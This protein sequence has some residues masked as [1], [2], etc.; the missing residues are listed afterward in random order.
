MKRFLPLLLMLLLSP[1][2]YS[3]VGTGDIAFLG[4]NIDA[5]T[6][7][8]SNDD[9]TFIVLE[10]IAGGE[11]FY[12]TEEGW[13]DVTNDWAGTSEG[14]IT[15]TAPV[16]GLACG[17][18]VH[19]NESSSNT[20]TVTGGGTATLGSGTGWSLTGGDQVIAYEAAV[21]EPSTVPTF[22]SGVHLDDGNGTPTSL[23]AV[24]GWNDASALVALGTAQSSLPPGLTNG[25]NC[26]SINPAI[27][28]EEDNAKYTGSLTGTASAVRALINDRLNWDDNDLTAYN[29]STSQF[30]A[31]VTCPAPCSDPTVPT[32]T[33][34]PATVCSGNN[35]TLN[36]SGTLNDATAWHVYTGSCGGT[37]VGSTM[38]SSISVTPSSPSTTY[39]VRG[40]GGCVTP[41]SCGSVTV[42][43]T[44]L[45]DAG[46]NYSASSYCVNDT[47][48]TPTITGLGG[49]TF[50][51]SPAGL[52]LTSGTGAIDVSL[53]TP[54]TYTVTYT[55]AGACPNSS[56][57]NVT[58]NG[59]DN[60]SFSYSASSYCVSDSDPTP[61]ITGLGGGTF[62]SSP[63][64][65]S[66]TS[67]T[68]AIDVS[69]STPGT[70]TVTYTT[71]GACP[72]SSNVNVT[73]NG[74]DNASF[75]Y[76]A[77]SYCVSDSDPT[78]TITGLGGGTFSS[79]P[80]G[81]SLTSGTGAIDV[82]LSTPGTYTVTYTTAGACPNSSN[83]NVTINGLDDASF[84]YSAA[85]YCQAASDPTPTISGLGGGTFSSSPAGLSLT[86]GTGA[87]DL[88][89]STPGTY[90]V[91]YT[92]AGACPNSSNVNV[93]VSTGS[94]T[95]VC[96]NITIYLD[97][98]GN[99]TITPADIDGGSSVSCGSL[100]LSASVTSFTCANIGP[101]IV[102][103]TVSNGLGNNAN[104][105][106][107]VTVSDTISPVITCP[108]NQTETPN[109]SCQFT[110][111]NYTG[112]A[113]ATDNC[114]GSPTIT[115]SPTAG[116]VISGNTTVTLTA[117]DGNGNTSSCTFDVTLNDATAPAA[118]C[119]NISVFLDGSGNATITAGDI[120]GGSSDNCSGISLSASPT[121]FTCADLGANNVTLT[122][123]DGNANQAAC[124]A[125]VTVL[126]TISPTA[127]C[128]NHTVTL[129]GSGNASMTAS[130]IDGGSSDNC[131]SV[132]LSAS[133]TAFT[134]ADIGTVNV[135]L[136]VDDGNGNTSICIAQV[137][138][139][140]GVSVPTTEI[141]DANC[142]TTVTM[143][144][145]VFA[146]P[147]S[148]AVSYR[149][150]FVATTGPPQTIV[151]DRPNYWIRPN[152]VPGILYGTTYSVTAAVAMT[153]GV[154]GPYGSTPCL[155]TTPSIAS[156][157][158]SLVPGDCGVVLTSMNQNIFAN[159]VPGA[160][161]YEFKWTELSTST[162]F[163][164][165]RTTPVIRASL[166]NGVSY[167]ET[168]LVSVRFQTQDGTWSPYGAICS[169]T[170]P[171]AAGLFTNIVTADCGGTFAMNAQIDADPVVGAIYY[172]F[173]FDDNVGNVYTR[174]INVP[175]VRGNQVVGLTDGT[176]DVDVRWQQGNGN[177][178]AYG[179][180]CSVTIGTPPP[181]SSY[182]LK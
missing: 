95:A 17:A 77:S 9:F 40:E 151:V 143:S 139:N 168:Y 25:V 164:R 35:A 136:T 97:G 116:T 182:D 126:D 102:T 179:T 140:A 26:V 103:L 88:S 65:L 133:Q 62:S 81:L 7:P 33:Y 166:I 49:G 134:T 132:S 55:T 135:T 59:L 27:G 107:V 63:A 45:D 20:F 8:T 121:A 141:V 125:V 108:G 90:T 41:G 19:I 145:N 18:V 177:W 123:T 173:R 30:S 142:G 131:G 58:I 157:S 127:I 149:Y 85:S 2:V 180:S 117:D 181:S 86:S 122:V 178:S 32:V 148:G 120:D 171:S 83:V 156:L 80:A 48:P 152:L 93:T 53:S 73:I 76:S 162:D 99:A 110:L 28:T 34:T 15:Y 150:Q 46:F 50:S 154:Y 64:G 115:Q 24:T 124:N 78:P 23:D 155:L 11:V 91:T 169:V 105:N 87:I 66:L 137:T 37:S 42:T 175:T 21:P 147:V 144:T 12:F 60:A 1:S 165:T 98:A 176:Y 36:I 13:N 114:S 104:C 31:S 112:L 111:P 138:V 70:Y 16:G 6:S 68:G 69:L 14:H 47:D 29:I 100:N 79:S 94:S 4:I 39:Y 52:S 172:E 89:L 163:Y 96:Q 44:A 118:V 67:G 119:Q 128:Q 82:S 84:N 160:V 56:N 75:S 5:G 38:G 146:T 61:T 159:S 74:L 10:P 101:N 113:T 72:N 170:T 54:G 22:I 3:Q 161:M 130:D 43:V 106:A 129:D 174:I 92:T 57:V 167:G 71:A 153:P 51:S 109:A 158:S